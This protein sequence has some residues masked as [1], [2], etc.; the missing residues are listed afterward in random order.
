MPRPSA[1]SASGARRSA[2]NLSLGC[3]PTGSRATALLGWSMKVQL[4][5]FPG[6]PNAI[7]AREL[8][9][10]LLSSSGIRA[11]LEEVNTTAPETPEQL[12]GW[13]S[14][15]ILINGVDIEGQDTPVTASCRLYR[16]SAGRLR[17]V[18]PEALLQAALTRTRM[19]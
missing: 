16:D 6:C 19:S 14:P 9:Q 3:P 12:R 5:T 2:A 13:G 8:I 1:L 17:G 7:A 18:P 10:R 4:L 15:T 11:S